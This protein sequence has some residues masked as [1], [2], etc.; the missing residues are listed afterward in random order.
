MAR[1]RKSG[2]VRQ[3]T[4]V[5][6]PNYWV[7][8]ALAALAVAL[9]LNTLGHRLVFDDLTLITQNPLVQRLDW[10][11]IVFRSGY[12]PV[13]TLTYA[14]NY[15]IGGDNP[16]GYHLFNV[17]LH[18]V[19][20][21]L[22]F[23]L[24]WRLTHSNRAA[25]LGALL[26]AVHPAQTAA[27]AYVSGR[28]DLLAALFMLLAMLLYL[29]FRQGGQRRWLKAGMAGGCF[30]LAVLSKEVAIVFP[31]L[32]LLVDAFQSQQ[33]AESRQSVVG[34]AWR[35]LRASPAM[36]GAF[37]V[38]ASLALFYA[39]FVAKASRMIG[40]WGGS[41]ET[42]LG[43][44][45]KLF[46]H[47]VRLAVFP[48]PLLAD[49]TGRVFPVS[50]G[51]LEPATLAAAVFMVAFL[52]LAIWLFSRYPL[53]SVGMLWFAAAVA[54]VLQFI[55]FHE[56]AAD[57]FLYVPLLGVAIAAAGGLTHL[58]SRPVWRLVGVGSAIVAVICAGMVVDRNRDW[59]DRRTLWEA[60]LRMAPGSYRA[61]ANLG[62]EY[63]DQGRFAEGLRLTRRAIEL[64][65][66]RALPYDNLGGMYY[67]VA[68][69]QRRAG[70]L[71]QA[72]Q[73]LQEARGYLN[74]ALERDAR[75]PFTYSN[76][77][78][79]Y[80]EMALIDDDRGS[81]DEAKAARSKAESLYRK[82]L[83]L[84]DPRF[85]VHRIWFNLGLLFVDARDYD[86]AIP[87][88]RRYVLSFPGE[89]KGN[90][91]Y[92]HALY[93][94][95]RYAAAIPSFYRALRSISASDESDLRRQT[96][97][98]MA[99]CFEQT[100]RLDRAVQ[101]YQELNRLSPSAENYYQLGRLLAREGKLGDAKAALGESLK[102][103]PWGN[104]GKKS[105]EELNR[106][107]SPPGMQIIDA[108]AQP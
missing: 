58:V 93:K 78:N 34:A 31:A 39:L 14:L 65:P 25:G 6:Q 2:R 51:L 104:W 60:T 49:Y 91:W 105:R 48:Y 61:N 4:V 99:V 7:G 36:Y 55:P 23:K 19:N 30:L 17:V 12:R 57:H 76:L 28:K 77:A 63:F 26:F 40:Y 9:Y 42:D 5:E 13:R 69:Q 88:L 45:F 94:E 100:N 66:E 21:V 86:R 68:Q 81:V 41:F 10:L 74:Q 22:L 43:T 103:D 15:A 59:R 20:V 18:S 90:Y 73:L 32:L 3:Q 11:G 108:K 35:A 27:V 67:L 84:P 89:P 37:V 44:S 54:P 102:T 24:L 38:L 56:L 83:S 53:V 107:E 97:S 79:T 106:L 96:I 47:Y 33:A 62:Q 16:F 82:A 87:Q 98:E 72:V 1:K 101:A 75:N 70:R 29:S 52:A 50:Q 80:K 8:A 92:G 64:S 95:G 85:D 71:A 46:F